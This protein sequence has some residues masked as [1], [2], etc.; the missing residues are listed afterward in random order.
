M[1]T[2]SVVIPTH[3]RAHLIGRSV[4]SAL[5]Q[6]YGDLEVVIVDDASTDGTRGAIARIADPRVKY[7]RHDFNRGVSAARNTAIA[8]AAGEFIAFLDDDDEWLPNKLEIQM[9]H[10]ERAKP[11]VGLVCAGFNQVDIVSKRITSEIIPT[12]RGWVFELLLRQG[13]FSHTSTIVVRAECFKKV[14]LFDVTYRYSE[15]FDMWVRIA[16][17]YEFDSIP[18]P[19]VRLHFQPDGLSR[20]YD[21][22]IAAGQAH[23]AKYREFYERNPAALKERLQNLGSCYLILGDAKRGRQMYWQAVARRPLAMKS[24]FGVALAIMGPWAFRIC[25]SAGVWTA[26]RRLLGHR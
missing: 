10:F 12:E 7:L 20:N 9:D 15:D 5:A 6:T 2:V 16:K 8:H 25:C 1:P 3:N 23:L 24:Y 26:A 4:R 19:L 22:M 14:G 17:E 11:S 18:I 21:A 13:T